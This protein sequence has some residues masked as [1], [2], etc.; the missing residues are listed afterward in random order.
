MWELAH[1]IPG[2]CCTIEGFY[3]SDCI[4]QKVNFNRQRTLDQLKAFVDEQ[5]AAG[6][7]QEDE[8]C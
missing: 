7:Q 8:V 2:S 3:Y 1:L 6:R 4:L 5:A